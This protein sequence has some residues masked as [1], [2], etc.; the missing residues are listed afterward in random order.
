VGVYRNNVECD[1]CHLVYEGEWEDDSL[2]PEDMAEA[3]VAAQVCPGCGHSQE[4]VY[5]GWAYQSEAG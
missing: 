2:D 3:P 1:S 4:E 5:P